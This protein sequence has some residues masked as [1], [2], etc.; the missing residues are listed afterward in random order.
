MEADFHMQTKLLTTLH[1]T[2]H[3]E[4]LCACNGLHSGHTEG[5]LKFVVTV[6]IW[7]QERRTGK[8]HHVGF[9]FQSY[10]TGWI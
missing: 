10:F 6:E 4:L 5:T 2:F 9:F 8:G 7:G 1:F 3:G